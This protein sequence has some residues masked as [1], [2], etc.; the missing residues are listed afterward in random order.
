M[1]FPPPRLAC[2]FFALAT[3]VA[4]SAFA[5]VPVEPIREGEQ[6]QTQIQG[7]TRQLVSSLDAMLGEYERNNLTGQDVATV[8]RLRRSLDTLSATEMRQV[9]DLLQ[10]ARAV[11]SADATVK[12]V[13]DA[14]TGQKQI[15]VA[16]KC[17]L[18]EHARDQEAAEISRQLHELADRQ[19]RNLQN[20]IQ[21]GRMTAGAKQ[22]NF[23]ALYQAQLE[24][25]RGEQSAIASEVKMI[26]GKVEK[27]AVS[28]ENADVADTFKTAAKQLERVE[29]VAASAADSLQ[30]GQIFKAASDEKTSREELRKI[31]RQIA[32]RE[33]GPEALR[34][35]ERELAQV[36][37]DQRQL[38]ESTAQQ[39]TQPDFDKWLAEKLDAN[40]QTDALPSR[41][42]NQP[43]SALNVKFQ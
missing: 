20:G 8:T 4:Q 15:I 12:T 24:T 16:I 9:V 21:L 23:E 28:P 13:A 14:F 33:Q 25:Q 35:A 41:F 39:R 2:R 10:R 38:K 18:A 31:A 27:F 11:N 19:G 17:I 29:P 43:A 22:E 3:L 7:E 26:R 30:A 5:Q 42:R 37:E 36:I 6:R 32:P 40:N 1:N 34:K